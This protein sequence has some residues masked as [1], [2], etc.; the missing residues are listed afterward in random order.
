MPP[1]APTRQ[2]VRLPGDHSLRDADGVH[3]AVGPWLARV[4]PD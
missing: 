1:E 4:V 3:Q 2:V